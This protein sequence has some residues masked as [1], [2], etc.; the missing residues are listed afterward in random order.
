MNTLITRAFAPELEVRAKGDGRT[1]FGIAVPYHTPQRIDPTL[2]EEFLVGAFDNQLRAAGA[3]GFESMCR[4]T[5]EHYDH[6]GSLIG[7]TRM[8]RDTPDG[9]YGEWYVSRTP[10]G[11]ET[12]EL[13]KDGALREL[14]IGFREGQNRRR[15]DGVVQRVTA[16]LHEVAVVMAGAYG[17]A[18]AAAG[19]RSRQNGE[20]CSTCTCTVAQRAEAATDSLTAV[21]SILAGLP[22]LPPA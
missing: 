5:R 20:H 21:R 17:E 13:V 22:A 7:A 3:R 4:F 19:V 1:I 11:D 14:S 16:T 18:A 2:T 8:L 9:L 12:L 10:L 6:G 15:T